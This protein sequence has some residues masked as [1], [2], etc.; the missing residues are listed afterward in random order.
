[1][2]VGCIKIFSGVE[3]FIKLRCNHAPVWL[4]KDTAASGGKDAQSFVEELFRIGYVVKKIK[5]VERADACV[6]NAA[7]NGTPPN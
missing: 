7:A 2:N 6:L 4:H 5:A 1:M 3:V